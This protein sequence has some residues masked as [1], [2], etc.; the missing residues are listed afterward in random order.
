[1]GLLGSKW[2]ISSCARRTPQRLKNHEL[3]SQT[4]VLFSL[5]KNLHYLKVRRFNKL[6]HNELAAG[7]GV[8]NLLW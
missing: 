6:L 8:K 1:M 3:G 2:D 7:D 4:I 5:K